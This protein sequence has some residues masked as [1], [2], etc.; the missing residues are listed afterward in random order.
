MKFSFLSKRKYKATDSYS[1]EYAAWYSMLDRCY[2]QQSQAWNNYGGR[3]I[4]VCDEWLGEDGF[5]N[6]FRDMKE[7]PSPNHSLDR[8]NNSLG[9]SPNNCRW[10]TAKIQARNRRSSKLIT[11]GSETKTMVEWC[12]VYSVEYGLVKDRIKDGWDPLKAF[13]TPK[14]RTYLNIGDVFDHWT[15]NYKVSDC[16]KYSCQCKC[17]NISIVSSYDLINGKSTKCKSCC[18]K[19]NKYAQV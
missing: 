11:I 6:F 3:G 16:N 4:K 8:I 19:G 9:Y 7:A 18:M 12:E 13:T 14:K 5:E 2:N 15:V 17:G 10:A 1:K